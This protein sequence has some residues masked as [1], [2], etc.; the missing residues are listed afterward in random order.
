VLELACGS[1]AFTR[2][3]VR[4][5]RTL[6]CVDGSPE[7]LKRNRETVADPQVEYICADLFRWQPPRTYD[8]VVFGFWLSHVPPARFERFWDLVASCLGPGGR[9]VFVDENERGAAHEA[10]HSDV[11]LPTARRRL[12]DG[13]TF[14]IAKVFWNER[15]LERRLAAIGWDA[16]VQ[17][18]GDT[19]CLGTARRHGS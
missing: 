1:G 2:E 15:E 3:V 16:R 14:E 13:R 11:D 8:D 12:S 5:A 10:D 17:P 4:H 9:A 19:C 7:M 18:L 6:T